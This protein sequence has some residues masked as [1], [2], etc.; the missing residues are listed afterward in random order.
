MPTRILLFILLR[1]HWSLLDLFHE[2][3]QWRRLAEAPAVAAYE[4]D[5]HA[6][7]ATEAGHAG[8]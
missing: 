1:L 3:E 7:P 2:D 4:V 8:V 6:E 5:A